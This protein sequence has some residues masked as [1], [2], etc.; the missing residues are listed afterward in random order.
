MEQERNRAIIAH[1]ISGFYAENRN[2]I[3]KKQLGKDFEFRKL[4]INCVA[5]RE[6]EPMPALDHIWYQKFAVFYT[7]AITIF[8]EL[9]PALYLLPRS[10]HKEIMDYFEDGLDAAAFILE[11]IHEDWTLEEMKTH[12][13]DLEE[14]KNG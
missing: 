14:I 5:V 3:I 11:V 12:F 1:I 7:P 4:L 2:P 13:D 10:Y 9:L 6:N 8:P